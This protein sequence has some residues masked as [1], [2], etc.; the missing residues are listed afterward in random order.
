MFGEEFRAPVVIE[1]P[2]QEGDWGVRDQLDFNVDGSS[3][4]TRFRE[5][6]RNFRQD[7]VY[8]Y[9]EALLRH[10]NRREFYIEVDLAH[11]NEFDEVLFNNLQVSL[12]MLSRSLFCLCSV[13]VFFDKGSSGGNAAVFRTRREGRVEGAADSR[14]PE[15]GQ[16]H[17]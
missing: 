14:K 5:F 12:Y 16:R 17:A 1:P 4:R 15:G 8:I 13:V 3:A 10:W 9:R 11:L 2:L 6:F 7:G